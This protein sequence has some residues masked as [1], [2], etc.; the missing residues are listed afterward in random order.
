MKSYLLKMLDIRPHEGLRV[1]LLLAMG[2]SMGMFLATIV[3][4]SQSLFLAHF[5]EETELPM[6]FLVSGAIGL[7]A[8]IAYNFLQ[9]R[10]PFSLLAGLSLFA[11]TALTLGLEFGEN[12]YGNIKDL[13]F[14][15][16]TLIIPFSFIVYLI[17][18]GTFARLFNTRQAKRLLGVVDAG[19]MFAS[20]IAYF[21]IPQILS[22]I[23]TVSL[24]TISVI[25]IGTF[26]LLFLYLSSRYLSKENSF[27]HEKEFHKKVNFT[28][29][30]KNRYIIFMALFVIVSM[31]VMNFVDYSFLNVTTRFFE[32]NSLPIF[33]SY[34]EMTIVIFNFLFQTFATDRIVSQYGMG[35]AMLIN[36]ILIGLFT[37]VAIGMGYAFGYEPSNSLFVVFFISIAMSKLFMSSLKDALDNQTFRLYLLP[38]EN[39]V[40]IDVQTKIEGTVTALATFLAGSIMILIN[41]IEVFDYFTVTIV[42]LPCVVAWFFISNGMHKGYQYTL[43]NTL[44]RNKAQH[45]EKRG[46]KGYTMSQVLETN[47]NSPAE[48]KAIYALRLMEH[49]EP[50]L[51]ENAI[52]RLAQS[53]YTR[54][55]A[56]AREK[57]KTLGL[58][59]DL[60]KDELKKLA[61]QAYNETESSDLIS[62]SPDKLLSLSKSVKKN[63]RALAAKLLRNTLNTKTV[64]I[65]LEL[66]RDPSPEVR[67]EALYT[68]R[69]VRRPETWPILIEQLSS[70]SFSHHAAAA[71]KEVGEDVLPSLEAAF[72]KSGQQEMVMLRIVQIM[73]R[74]GGSDALDLLWQKADYPDKRVVKQILY[75]LR[76]INYQASGREVREV[77]DLLETE[78]GKTIWNLA[79]LHELPKEPHLQYLREALREEV[80]ENYEQ[81]GMLLSILYD[82]QW[83]QL[84]QENI[85]TG[86]ADSIAF[87]LE[88]LDLFVDPDLKPK[89]FPLFDDSPIPD[90]LRLLQLYYPR[91]RYNPTQV[92]NY[93]LNR[94]FNFNN[95]WTKACAIHAAAYLTDFRIS[96]GLAAQVFNT[97]KLLQETAAWV[98][99]NKDEQAYT[100]IAERLPAREKKYL[101]TSIENNQ[102]LDGL[103]DGFFLNIEMIMV[104]KE[105][106]LFHA[107]HGIYISDLADRIKPLSLSTREHVRFDL[108]LHNKPLLIVAYGNVQFILEDGQR[109]AGTR[110]TIW[111]DPFQGVPVPAVSAIEALDR[112]VIFRIDLMDFYFV[113]ANHH[114]LIQGVI[115]NISPEKDITQTETT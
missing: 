26:F 84:V 52:I 65:L 15:G 70:P 102:L 58:D 48:E 85:I 9:N 4:A 47:A 10:I 2:F 12:W 16:F 79:A 113:M 93:I 88:L 74:I 55:Q 50:A 35:T 7:C 56:F 41:K 81:L 86:D 114:E 45:L 112:A 20:F 72:H 96:R 28:A 44:A 59:R 43:Q 92:I 77:T 80:A 109:V 108:T 76:Y 104:I 27:A 3:V 32:Q 38:I 100:D 34:F 91:E 73:G 97:D 95:R 17:F 71:L 103:D 40:R 89:L 6:A 101:D 75:S 31:L 63:D 49:L 42:T 53:H 67:Y 82:P 90:K 107:V 37:A 64:F 25:S 110:G 24:Y 18:W 5:D 14:I 83:V 29:F 68:A 87:A 30:F 33:I 115:K 22:R 13:Y 78:I 62:I 11:A 19:A 21:S 61:T 94:D 66:L 51:F 57:I 60:F 106:P 36:P 1:A 105:L 8:T 69:K 23:D 39:N 98:I 46:E 111:G 54:V 99:Y